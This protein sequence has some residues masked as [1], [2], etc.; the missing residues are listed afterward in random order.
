MSISE[1]AQHIGVFKY[2]SQAFINYLPDMNY[3][4]PRCIHGIIQGDI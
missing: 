4:I 1:H 3:D 2:K